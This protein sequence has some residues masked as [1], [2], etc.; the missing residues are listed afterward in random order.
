MRISKISITQIYE[1]KGFLCL[2]FLKIRHHFWNF[3]ENLKMKHFLIFL[4]VVTLF[5]C[6]KKAEENY[7][8]STDSIKTSVQKKEKKQQSLPK[9]V[10]LKKMN[11]ELLQA[12]KMADY[13]AF[14]NHIHPEKGIRFSMYAFTNRNEDKHFSKS[15][16]Q[17]YFSTKTIFTW[18]S[19]DGTGEMYQATIKNY[20]RKWV[21]KKDPKSDFTENY[22]P[23]S[24]QYSEMDW[25][26]LRFV[27]EEFEGEFYLV[28]VINDEWTV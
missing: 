12:I 8:P 24:E 6:N 10:V 9:E 20:F 4:F 27:F 19:L 18:G 22:I 2:H 21:F 13:N 15:D 28:A 14:A 7:K 5:S 26:S 1:I 23:G 11:S 17:K 25:K 3:K 16:F